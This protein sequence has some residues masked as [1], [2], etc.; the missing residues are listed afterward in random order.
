MHCC[1][2]GTYSELR[3]YETLDLYWQTEPLILISSTLLSPTPLLLF[4]SLAW[5]D[6]VSFDE[7]LK[8]LDRQQYVP[9]WCSIDTSLGSLTVHLDPGPVFAAQLHHK[10]LPGITSPHD[11]IVNLGGAVVQALLRRYQQAIRADD[12]LRRQDAA[13][14]PEPTMLEPDLTA[15]LHGEAVA[16][17]LSHDYFG[18]PE[19]IPVV[20]SQI[21]P[22]QTIATFTVGTAG[23]EATKAKL[24]AQC[25]SWLTDAL[26]NQSKTPA[27]EA[28]NAR[29]KISFQL[30]PDTATTP[31]RQL[32]ELATAQFDCSLAILIESV[33]TVGE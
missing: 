26:F 21:E 15:R 18:S 4:L 9:K 11:E 1:I 33:S 3:F 17:K 24:V 16:H 29:N 19:H 23:D 28:E 22:R 31:E 5:R 6:K 10:M 25:P 30:T 7:T 32:P 20:L 12:H 13:A 14:V 8:R 2:T 27:D